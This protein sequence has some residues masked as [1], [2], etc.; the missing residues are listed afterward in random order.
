MGLG[1]QSDHTRN[2]VVARALVWKGI[3]PIIFKKRREDPASAFSSNRLFLIITNNLRRKLREYNFQLR[4]SLR[5][6][7]TSFD[8]HRFPFMSDNVLLSLFRFRRDDIMRVVQVM[9]W[10]LNRKRTKRNRYSVT[11]LLATC[12]VL[13]RLASATRWRDLEEVFCR[14]TSQ[15]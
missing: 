15:L 3:I 4:R 10:P 5:I 13:R 7:I 2:A 9:S 11:P 14:H 1:R 8:D 6:S 12:V